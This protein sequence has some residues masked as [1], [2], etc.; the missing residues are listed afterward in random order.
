M[1]ILLY[2]ILHHCVYFFSIAPVGKITALAIG[3]IIVRAKQKAVETYLEISVL[4]ID[5][6]E[7][8]ITSSNGDS[9]GMDET[10]EFFTEVLPNNATYNNVTWST[11]D[12]SIATID[13]NG[14]LTTHSTGTVMVIATTDGGF[15]AEYKLN[16][17]S[18]VAGLVTLLGIGG[19]AAGVGVAVKKRKKK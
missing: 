9:L 12:S 1:F 16:V 2:H 13:E 19:A 14:I 15:V 18:P 6:T 17:V 3:T 7:I 5:E 11:S 4:P 10:S 8:I